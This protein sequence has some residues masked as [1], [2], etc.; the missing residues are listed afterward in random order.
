MTRRH[1][2]SLKASW[3]DRLGIDSTD[4]V[5]DELAAC[6]EHLSQYALAAEMPW[7]GE[8]LSAEAATAYGELWVLAGF[9]ADVQCL[10]SRREAD[11]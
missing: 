6:F 1:A 8:L 10:L 4:A 3:A 9:L 5:G 11:R 2:M 7:R